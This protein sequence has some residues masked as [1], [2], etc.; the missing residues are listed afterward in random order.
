MFAS[1]RHFLR[2]AVAMASAAPAYTALSGCSSTQSAESVGLIAD[3]EGWLD[4]SPGFSYVRISPTGETMSDGLLVPARHDGMGAFAVE[5]AP[6]KVRLVRN[7]EISAGRNEVG[8]FDKVPADQAFPFK[9][10]IYDFSPDGAPLKGGTTTLVYNTKTQ[11]LESSHLSLA[12]TATNC[13]GGVT[14]WG[15][16]LTCE[17]TYELPGRHAGKAHGFVFEV[18]STSPGPVQPIALTDMGRFK[19]E[20]A[21]V[22]PRTGIVYLTEDH[23]EGLFY[24]FLP[25][26]KGELVQGGR[27]QALALMDQAGAE[28]HNRSGTDFIAGTALPVRWID[29]DHVKA[30]DGDLHLRGHAAG[31]ARFVRGE[32]MAWAV[33]P[34]GTAVYFACTTGGKAKKGQ[35]WRYRPSAYEGTADEASAPG[36]LVLHY[37]SPSAQ[38]MDMCDNLVA[39]PWGHLI[40]C[41]DGDN[42]QFVHGLSPTGDVYTIAR[43]A[44]P[45]K[46][47]FAGACFS[48]D[49]TTL[50]VNVQTPGATYAI[51]GPWQNLVVS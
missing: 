40:I 27:L 49:G 29:L 22:D 13:A 48:P 20:A 50:F 46:S 43:N 35:I 2:S 9:D 44:H 15:S 39:A 33:E 1:R 42:D 21:A 36:Q 8:A 5:G 30:P 3:P 25:N 7:H 23:E 14:P 16:W 38:V 28:T 4:L 31:A 19:H 24:R 37:E 26:A 12:G 41:E 17:E 18:P 34:Q 51:T 11:N 6:E 32:G 10:M 47:E 45:G